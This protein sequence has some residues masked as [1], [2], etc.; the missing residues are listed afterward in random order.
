MQRKK[1]RK[2]NGKS[3][4][5]EVFEA[6]ARLPWWSA[7]LAAVISY[8]WLHHLALASPVSP[9][10]AGK[11]LQL[12]AQ[13]GQYLLPFGFGLSALS[14]GLQIFHRRRLLARAQVSPDFADLARLS[15]EE[16]E[17]LVGEA[18]RAQGFAV[19]ETKAG[20]D[21]GID[22]VLRKQ[23]ERFLVQCKRWRARTVGVEI[24]REL[25][26]V[27]AAQGAVGGYV[28][29]SGIFTKEA[30]KF[31]AGRDIDL[32]DGAKLK[33]IIRGGTSSRPR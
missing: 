32:W 20:A 14:S 21:G 19:S 24:V 16:F 13:G 17:R 5:V 15:W 11:L 1:T 25:Y 2:G 12:A 26:G 27:M 22:L 18:F 3:L 6:T 23:G 31:A 28:V 30:Y 33:Q 9:D 4:L 10:L 8:L 7:L 29:T